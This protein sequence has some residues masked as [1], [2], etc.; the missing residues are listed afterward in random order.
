MVRLDLTNRLD[1]AGLDC[2]FPVLFRL[3]RSVSDI[4]TFGGRP[5]EWAKTSPTHTRVN[6]RSA[7][8][9]VGADHR[10]YLHA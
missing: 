3:F 8:R 5:G 6:K 9:K 1:I 4:R 7:P 2:V 10:E